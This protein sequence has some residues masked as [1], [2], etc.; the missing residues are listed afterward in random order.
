[1]WPFI[2][3]VKKMN[4]EEERATLENFVDSSILELLLNETEEEK[5]IVHMIN[6]ESHA[7][8]CNLG[9]ICTPNGLKLHSLRSCNYFHPLLVQLSLNCTRKHVF[10]IQIKLVCL[11]FFCTHT[12]TYIHTYWHQGLWRNSARLCMRIELS[13]YVYLVVFYHRAHC[14]R[15][16]CLHYF[17]LMSSIV[18]KIIHEHLLGRHSFCTVDRIL[19]FIMRLQNC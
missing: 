1:M 11:N 4:E 15:C 7:L 5:D 10:P 17:S 9:I 18:V 3:V 12:H 16:H 6:R 13:L 14:L 8:L 19:I 2:C